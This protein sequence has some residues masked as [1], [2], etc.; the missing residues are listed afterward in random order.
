MKIAFLIIGTNKYLNLAQNCAASIKTYVKIPN[1]E[2]KCH[3]FSNCPKFDPYYD[4]NLY[5]QVDHLPWPLITLLRYHTFLRYRQYLDDYDY[6]YY[7][8]SDMCIINNIGEEILGERVALQHP[9]LWGQNQHM[10]FER[11]PNSSAYMPLSA[12]RN[13]YFG[14]FQGGSKNEF[15]KMC[16]TLNGRIN[17]D[18]K[19]NHIAVWHDESQYN[20]YCAEN[21]PTVVLDKKYAHV[22]KWFGP[23]TK[24]T[25]IVC[26]EKDNDKMRKE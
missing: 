14:A 13:Y 9:G 18:L 8:D 1:C 7:I 23:P 6:I 24:E 22:E 2:V 11:N 25:K 4:D 5:H 10:P 17:D 19:K 12:Y 3:I 16:E 26:V 21:R 20:K 15:L